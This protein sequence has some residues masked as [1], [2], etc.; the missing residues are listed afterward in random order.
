MSAPIIDLGTEGTQS[1]IGERAFRLGLLRRAGLPVPDGFII[2]AGAVEDWARNDLSG[3]PLCHALAAA[4]ERLEVRLSQKFA[5]SQ[6]PFLLAVRQ[7][8]VASSFGL[9]PTILN[10]GTAADAIPGL[11]AVYGSAGAWWI[12]CGFLQDFASLALGAEPELFETARRG[13]VE[14]DTRF[15]ER[16][17]A[18]YREALAGAGIVVPESG[19]GQ[20]ETAIGCLC[21]P[22]YGPPA[23]QA[24]LVQVMAQEIGGPRPGVG[25]L[26]TRKRPDGSRNW[27]A[28]FRSGWSPERGFSGGS[29]PCSRTTTDA[30]GVWPD[31]GDAVRRAEDT[32][33]QAL[34]ISFIV[35]FDGMQIVGADPLRLEPKGEAAVTKEF[36]DR[37]VLTKE[38]AVAVIDPVLVERML[39]GRVDPAVRAEV[40]CS[41]VAA[42]PGAAV[43]E[44]VFSAAAAERLAN[45]GGHP[46]LART[47]TNPADVGAMHFA[48]AVITSRG[49]MTSHAAVVTRALGRPCVA[50]IA[51]LT[52]DAG[53]RRLRFPGGSWYEEGAQVTVDGSSGRLLAGTVRVLPPEFDGPMAAIVDWADQ[54]RRMGVRANA[55][56]TGDARLALEFRADGIG[57]CRTEHMFFEKGRIAAMREMILAGTEEERRIALQKL[58][59]MQ[60]HDLRE[61][62]VVMR[63]KPVVIRLL[64]PPLHEFLP[65]GEREMLELA[66]RMHVPVDQ[67]MTRAKSLEEF[68]PMLGNRGC[69]VGIAFPEIYEMQAR[70]IL[71]AAIEAGRQ[72]DEPAQPEIMVPLVSAHREME[73]LRQV[74]D[75]VAADVEREFGEPVAYRVGAMIETPRAALRSDAISRSADFLSYGTNDLTQMAFGLSRDDAGRFMPQYL[76]QQVYTADP[77]TTIDQEG[78]GELIEWSVRRSRKVRSGIALGLCGEHGADPDSLAFCEKLGIDY[79]SCS[80]FRLPVARL[81]AAQAAIARRNRGTAHD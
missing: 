15:H 24:I 45:R 14:S 23:G 53:G 72:T 58:L 8:P 13:L 77:F 52:I 64:D 32:L 57:L 75:Q 42:A 71:Q 28:A 34:E 10:V 2:T 11:A 73:I 60:L 80:P 3:S 9:H 51:D 56:T 78:V 67:V 30:R 35:G 27:V 22:R 48:K 76:R 65:R 69:R 79:V 37:S 19:L 29:E 61:L 12:R 81:S 33:R 4:V 54:F 40:I 49:G 31:L 41:G 17:A 63:G 50:G 18:L 1:Q 43:G 62:F 39:H 36:V 55:D 25:T 20:L 66:E 38:E 44:L 6:A 16:L 70:A 46:V 74:V 26:R 21:R 47:E 68:N 59:P 5:G 7:S